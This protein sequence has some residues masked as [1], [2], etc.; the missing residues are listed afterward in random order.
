[1]GERT[2]DKL[3]EVFNGRLAA[4]DRFAHSREPPAQC[5]VRWG[6]LG[7]PG[8]CGCNERSDEFEGFSAGLYNR[9]TVV[10]PLCGERKARRAC[11]ALGLQ[12]CAVCCGTKRLAQLAC[13]RP[14]AYLPASPDH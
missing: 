8:W 12:I 14:C 6:P 1:M 5:V 13:P 9:A 4:K 7:G 3:L 2:L 11:P 10:C